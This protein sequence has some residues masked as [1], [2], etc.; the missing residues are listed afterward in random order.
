MRTYLVYTMAALAEIA[1][2]FSA[3]AYFRRG[4]SAF[5]LVPGTASLLLFTFLLAR[6]E[7]AAG[8]TFAAYGGVYIAASLVWLWSVEGIRPDRWDLIGAVICL[9]G[10]SI[11]LLGPRPA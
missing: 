7:S 10:A 6:I 4:A 1:G 2:C 11:I 9:A 3:W 8:R 5:W